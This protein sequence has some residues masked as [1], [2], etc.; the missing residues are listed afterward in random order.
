M[1]PTLF[2]DPNGK[3]TPGLKPNFGHGN[4]AA[5]MIAC[6]VSDARLRRPAEARA[7]TLMEHVKAQEKECSR[8]VQLR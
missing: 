2:S 6:S 7:C 1:R 4:N 3:P 5:H 8:F